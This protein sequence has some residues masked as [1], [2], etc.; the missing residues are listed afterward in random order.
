ME[1]TQAPKKSI[2]AIVGIV[3]IVALIVIGALYVWG[4]TK[5]GPTTNPADMPAPVVAPVSQSDE[6][7]SIDADLKADNAANVDLT[8]I[9]EIK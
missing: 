5:S 4:G 8:G 6:I 7:D 2:G 3:I 9:D 1:P